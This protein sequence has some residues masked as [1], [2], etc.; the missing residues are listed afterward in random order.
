MDN[1]AQTLRDIPMPT[2]N[3]VVDA[4]HDARRVVMLGLRSSFALAVFMGTVLRYAGKDVT[5]LQGEHGD[6]W[7]HAIGWGRDDVIVGISFPRYTRLTV[8][9]MQH[10]KR[11]GC[12]CIGITDS[13]VA[14]LATQ[15]HLVLTARC[16]LDSYIESFTAV[17]S[18]VNAIVTAISIRD[19]K[20]TL[21]SLKKF[22]AMWHE[23]DIYV[24]P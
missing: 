19:P 17:M 24:N 7:D 2:F 3:R 18:L 16:A 1:L 8:E 11:Q 15:C 23:R 4:I 6:L 13:A 20:R 9:A 10:A 14:P 21:Q 5:V 22:E 12:M